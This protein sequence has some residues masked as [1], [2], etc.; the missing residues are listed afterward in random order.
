MFNK[1]PLVNNICALFSPRGRFS[2]TKRCDQLGSKRTVAAKH[3]NKKLLRR[4]Q[5]LQEVRL[6]QT[7][8]HPNLVKLLDTYETGNSYVL[9]LEM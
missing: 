9:V 8:D 3:V 6:L 2:V 7:V 1:A 5:V 4:E